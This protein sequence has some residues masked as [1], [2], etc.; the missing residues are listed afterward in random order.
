MRVLF[1]TQPGI[2]HLHPLLPLARGMA[3]QGHTV[4]FACARSFVPEVGRA[5]CGAF[6]VGRDWLT[7]E[8]EQAFPEIRE[9]PPG[10]T[11]YAWVRANVFAGA[12]ARHAVPDLLALSRVWPPDLIVRDAAEYGGCLAAELLGIPHAVVRTDSGSSSYPGRYLV[13]KQ[14]DVARTHFGLAPDPEVA[15]PFRF[16][17]LSFATGLDDPAELTAPTHHRLRP[18]GTVLAP[19]EGEEG[20]RTLAWLRRVPKRSTVY[21]TLGAVYNNMVEVFTAILRSLREEPLNLILTVGRNQDPAQFGCQPVHVHIE[22]FVPQALLLPRCD[23][24]VTHGGFGTV[25]AA[26]AHG[27]PLVLIPI[28][29]DQPENARRCAALGVGHIVGPDKRTPPIIRAAVR[30]VLDNPLYRSNAQRL[31]QQAQTLPGLEHGIRLLERLAS[32]NA[33]RPAG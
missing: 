33:P 1:T 26:L 29:A 11:R 22:R 7:I 3:Q 18:V 25:T 10:P 23:L 14:L 9:V 27:L 21:A 5:G 15:M 20:E 8:L 12:T 6:P 17:H 24:V 31:R 28:S 32:E 2:G 16:L 30:E 19:E 13:S 4:A